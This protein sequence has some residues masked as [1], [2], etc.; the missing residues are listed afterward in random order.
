MFKMRLISEIHGDCTGEYEVKLDKQYTVREF[1]ETILKEKPKEW[2][3]I[4][5]KSNW[6]EYKYGKVTENLPVEYLDKIVKEVKV[7]G[8]WSRMDYLITIL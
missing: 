8:G 6:F 1:I 7:S 5:I 3:N 2:G 4:G